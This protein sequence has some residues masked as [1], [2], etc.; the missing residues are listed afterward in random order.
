MFAGRRDQ[1]FH[2]GARTLVSRARFLGKCLDLPGYLFDSGTEAIVR[3][4]GLNPGIVD[5]RGKLSRL[6]LGVAP[7][8]AI[9]LAVPAP[10]L[11]DA[12]RNVLD[13]VEP[14]L[15]RLG[16]LYFRS[17]CI[18]LPSRT[19]R[20]AKRRLRVTPA[21]VPLGATMRPLAFLIAF[22]F[23]STGTVVNFDTAPLGRMPPGWTATMTNHGGAP[24]WQVIR[25]QSAP[26]QPYVFA[27]VSSDPTDNRCP[28]AIYDSVTLKNGDLSVRIK[29]VS[30]REDRSGGIVWRYR[31][32]N[33]YYL[34]RANALNKNVAI[35]RFENGR[36]TQLGLEVKHDIPSNA[37]SILKV[38]VRGERFQVYVNHRRIMQGEDRTF[39][40]PG[41]VGLWT[42]ADSVTYFDDFRV[43]PK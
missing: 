4:C 11:G 35:Y 20:Y 14:L 27:Q 23:S 21:T 30:G 10:L 24:V 26:T 41:K 16:R 31:D 17:Q 3:D 33:N 13:S 19:V 22:G 42:V 32:P 6:T 12:G 38:S 43:Y 18:R 9:L 37:W 5:A 29:P 7:E 15:S 25:D 36:R 39:S 34:V 1:R 40:G 8:G 2:S 28:L